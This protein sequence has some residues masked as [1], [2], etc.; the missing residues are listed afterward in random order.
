M[1]EYEV[2]SQKGEL[3]VKSQVKKND[4]IKKHGKNLMPDVGLEKE[5]SET[6]TEGDADM[7]SPGKTKTKHP[8]SK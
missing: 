1:I 8:N 3:R 4:S 7:N 5:S 6:T 2:K